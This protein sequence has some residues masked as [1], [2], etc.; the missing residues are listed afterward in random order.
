MMSN[1]EIGLMDT[2]IVGFTPDEV[3]KMAHKALTEGDTMAWK[4]NQLHQM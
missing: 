4:H 3:Y 2:I 1:L